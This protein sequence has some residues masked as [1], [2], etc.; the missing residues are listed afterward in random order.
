[1]SQFSFTI[2]GLEDRGSRVRFP[3]VGGNFPLHHRVQDG[4]GVHP[5][6]YPMGNRGSFMEEK[7]PEREADH[8]PPS[9]AENKEC[10]EL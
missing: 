6:G 5:A 3:V 10:V 8:L 1:V 9:T 2:C 4:S 7:R